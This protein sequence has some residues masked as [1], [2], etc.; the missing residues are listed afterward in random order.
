MAEAGWYQDPHNPAQQRY[1]DGQTWTEHTHVP[2]PFQA[3]QGDPAA[4]RVGYQPAARADGRINDVGEWFNRS[5]RVVFANA[6]SLIVLSIITALGII[7]P[8]GAFFAG[9]GF[10]QL[11]T[12]P[13]ILDDPN[14][15]PDFNAGLL[16][17]AGLLFLLYIIVSTVISLAQFYILHRG[18]TGGKASLGEAVGAGLRRFPRF[19]GWMLVILAAII[20]MFL[21]PALLAAVL[22]EDGWVV[23]LLFFLYLPLSIWLAI[24]LSMFPVA[25]AVAPS[26]TN[27]MSQSF[28]MTSGHGLAIFGR[29]LL[30][31]L[32]IVVGGWVVSIFGLFLV[33]IPL[34]FAAES[35]GEV[36]F[37]TGEFVGLGL[38]FIVQ[39]LVSFLLALVLYSGLA[40][41]YADLGGPAD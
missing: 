34:S 35:G 33:G 6:G 21:A 30:I 31:Y 22:G 40:G 4:Y 19:L 17:A 1:W 25:A 39:M 16:A 36:D 23:G 10:G 3:T 12:E 27:V 5:F 29:I 41:I 7:V 14:W 38:Y 13:E 9:L 37:G 15:S 28:R 8:Y 11:F 2:A 26:G 20:V 18:H 24:R 32:I